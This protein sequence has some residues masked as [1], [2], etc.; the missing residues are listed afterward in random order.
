MSVPPTIHLFFHIFIFNPS[1]QPSICFFSILCCYPSFQP[2]I[3]F[4]I[5]P[6]IHI[7]CLSIH[8]TI[9]LSFHMFVIL[10][11][12]YPSNFFHYFFFYPSNHPSIYFF[13]LPTIIYIFSIH[14]S[15]HPCCSIHPLK[16]LPIE[17][18]IY[19]FSFN[20]F[21][22]IQPS[23]CFYPPTLIFLFFLSIQPSIKLFH[24]LISIQQSI[25][26][27]IYCILPSTQPSIFYIH[28]IIHPTIHLFFSYFSYLSIQ[29]SMGILYIIIMY[30]ECLCYI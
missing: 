9:H 12:N 3:Y 2:S 18:C 1:N 6:T 21:L 25:Y 13:I 19:I 17:P 5:H 30:D 20:F 26:F 27:Y 8:L 16:K 24:F 22:Y 28:P 4:S 15:N 7:F 14:P 11:T 10:P 23:I 29:Q